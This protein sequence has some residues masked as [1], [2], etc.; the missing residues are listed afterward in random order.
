MA[1]LFPWLSRSHASNLIKLGFVKVAGAKSLRPGLK[2]D[3]GQTIEI[4]PEASIFVSQSGYKLEYALDQFK[5]DVKDLVALDCGLS[6]GGFTQCLLGRGVQ[7]VYGV[8]VGTNQVDSQLAQDPRLVVMEQT[9][10]KDLNSLPDKIELFTL[11]L[12]FISLTKV[13]DSVKSL[14]AKDAKIVALIKP[15]FEADKKDIGS[16]GIVKS[17]PARQAACQKVITSA[18]SHGFELV[19]L[20][21]SPIGDGKKTNIEFLALFRTP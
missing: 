18:Q 4:D 10:F 8:D 19:S 9:N 12:S 2:V 14:A 16:D 20:M 1:R 13:F 17:E 6:T 15:Q 21:P 7:K 11:D 5:L 3:V